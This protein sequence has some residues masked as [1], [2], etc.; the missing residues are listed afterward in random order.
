MLVLRILNYLN[1][2]IVSPW[3]IKCNISQSLLFASV[4]NCDTGGRMY[5]T[6]LKWKM[7]HPKEKQWTGLLFTKNHLSRYW[8]FLSLINWILKKKLE[9]WFVFMKCFSPEVALYLFISTIQ[10]CLEYCCHV[11]VVAPSCF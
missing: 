3:P 1:F 7:N 2:W 8:D 9:P 4:C 5:V 6:L 11:W 10:P